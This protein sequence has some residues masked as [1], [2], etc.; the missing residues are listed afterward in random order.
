MK[1]KSTIFNDIA[2]AMIGVNGDSIHFR[3]MTDS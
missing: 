1:P 2:V 3:L